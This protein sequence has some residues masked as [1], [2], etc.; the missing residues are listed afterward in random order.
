MESTKIILFVSILLLKY[1]AQTE[2]N[3]KIWNYPDH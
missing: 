3:I 1:V 2:I